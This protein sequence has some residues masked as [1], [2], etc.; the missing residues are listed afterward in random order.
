MLNTFRSLL[1]HLKY[2]QRFALI[3]LL[4]LLPVLSF[5]PI[6]Q[7]LNTRLDQYG[8]K[9]LQGTLYLR[10]LEDLLEDVQAHQ[11]TV[12]KFINGQ[13]SSEEL[14]SAQ[15]RVDAD[16]Q[17]LQSVQQEEALIFLHTS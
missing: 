14:A 15:A 17:A 3:S 5:L 13:A 4:F 11:L 16:F 8:H 2:P 10:P 7:E 9:E 12:E 6:V 1:K